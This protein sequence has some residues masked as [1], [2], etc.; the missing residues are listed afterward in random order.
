M[1]V[2]YKCENRWSQYIKHIAPYV[3]GLFLPTLLDAYFSSTSSLFYYKRTNSYNHVFDLG[4][5]SH[6]DY[7]N[8][9]SI[10]LLQPI[11]L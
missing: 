8:R 9:E 5:F 11:L 3:S 2:D 10:S 4:L 7:E 6:H 1:T